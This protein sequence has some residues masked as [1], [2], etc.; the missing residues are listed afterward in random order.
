ME[1]GKL[2]T[3]I[4]QELICSVVSMQDGK[5][6]DDSLLQ[7][8]FL[9]GQ[10][11]TAA[12]ELVDRQAVWRLVAQPSGRCCFQI[13]GKERCICLE[14]YCSC[15]NFLYAVAIKQETAFCKH[16]LAATLAN[17]LGKVPL[18]EVS[19]TEYATILLDTAR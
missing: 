13:V 14:H 19:D 17:V 18:K 10:T 4:L 8:H 16:Q 6:S 5:L 1:G 11:L 12:L 15:R 3:V 2:D 7:L 9:F